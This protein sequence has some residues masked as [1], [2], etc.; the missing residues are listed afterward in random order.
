MTSSVTGSNPPREFIC[1][2]CGKTFKRVVYP[3]STGQ[4]R[5]CSPTCRNKGRHLGLPERTIEK[6]PRTRARPRKST[7]IIC[8]QCG[9]EFMAQPSKSRKFCSHECYSRSLCK[10]VE[11]VCPQCGKTFVRSPNRN[12]TFC[13][14]ECYTASRQSPEV[15]KVCPTCGTQ[16]AVSQHRRAQVYCSQECTPQRTQDPEKRTIT[17]CE[18]CGEP[19]VHYKS[20]PRKYCSNECKWEAMKTT[21]YIH[22][23]PCCGEEY[24]TDKKHQ[25]F[26]S[27]ECA[28]VAKRGEDHPNWKGGAS[29]QYGPNWETQKRKAKDRDQHTC[30]LCGYESGG[31]TLLDVHHIIPYRE[32][33]DDWETAN[34]LDNLISL[35]RP[36]HVKVE[37]SEVPCPPIP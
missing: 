5:F 29:V 7:P 27:A 2:Y 30:Q 6:P 36:C 22:T 1:Q 23:C 17:T 28:G 16:F 21:P 25:E 34:V 26:C 24:E 37:R 10:P 33:D 20:N 15:K 4:F 12:N 19:F 13:S 18:Q 9:K 11:R 31:D 32:F 3:S 35:C 8:E 14:Q